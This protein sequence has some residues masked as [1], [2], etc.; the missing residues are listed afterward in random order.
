VDPD[1]RADGLIQRLWHDAKKEW[2]YYRRA[3]DKADRK[4][5]LTERALGGARVLQGVGEAVAAGTLAAAPDPTGLT[6]I[7]SYAVAVH[8]ADTAATGLQQ[9][10]TGEIQQT[11][12]SRLAQN[13]AHKAGLSPEMAFLLGETTD[14]V[15]SVAGP[16]AIARL[17]VRP[18]K[19]PLSPSEKQVRTGATS[20][21]AG[22][23][24]RYV[25]TGLDGK[26]LPLPRGPNGELLP[27]SMAPHTQIGWKEGRRG[28]YVQT[29]E[30]SW[31]GE[32][33]KQVDW[34]NHG[35]PQEHTN[36][37]IHDYVPN[38]T[39]GTPQ[40]GPPRPPRPGEL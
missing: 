40:H 38:P 9:M 7:G 1:G 28:G 14:A 17:S 11:A 37:H 31:N 39:G 18:V 33:V 22:G 4:Y 12:T 2:S 3:A 27:S 5:H 13:V 15:A 34:T 6:K 24:P 29:R 36:P 26:P 30:F 32:P 19:A 8:A 23:Q 25:P 10:M 20:G 16:V 35:R 21:E